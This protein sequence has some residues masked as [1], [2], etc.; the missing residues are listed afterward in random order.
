MIEKTSGRKSFLENIKPQNIKLLGET[1][2]IKLYGLKFYT[3]ENG[4]DT[5]SEIEK[6]TTDSSVDYES[7]KLVAEDKTDYKNK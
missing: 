4:Q 3:P 1:G 7:F 6:L 2:E 5:I